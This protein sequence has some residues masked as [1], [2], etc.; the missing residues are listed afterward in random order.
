MQEGFYL[1]K[2]GQFQSNFKELLEPEQQKK[3]LILASNGDKNAQNVL[4]EHNLRLVVDI[5][6]KYFPEKSYQEKEELFSVGTLGLWEAIIR[7]DITNNTEL[8]TYAVPYILGMMRRHI[9]NN[10]IIK[11]PPSIK[12]LQ[13]KII[14][15]QR[16]YN[17]NTGGNEISVKEIANILKEKEETINYVL[18]TLTPVQ[19]LQAPILKSLQ[20]SRELTLEETLVDRDFI[21]DEHLL[22]E[23]LKEQITHVLDKLTESQKRYI[24]LRFGFDGVKRERA[25]VT[26]ILGISRQRSASLEKSALKRILKYLPQSIKKEYKKVKQK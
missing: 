12:N 6:N 7:Y 18:S 14:I 15:I 22:N 9:Q 4:F 23:E 1:Y 13:K 20:I 24:Y 5:L 11:Y 16:E 21:I 26:K 10:V 8:S 19:H 3:L 25:D 17:Y 2:P